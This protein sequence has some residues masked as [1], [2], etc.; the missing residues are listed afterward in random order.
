MQSCAKSWGI[1]LARSV[2][3]GAPCRRLSDKSRVVWK[4]HSGIGNSGAS[5]LT[6]T[7][8][9]RTTAAAASSSSS[10]SSRQIERILP[11]H[12][13]FSERH[14]GPG[15]REKREMLDA[16]GVETLDQLI[17]DTVP[18][19]IRMRRSMKMDDPIC[20]SEILD[21]L[22][23]IASKNKVWRSY[24][25]MGYYNCLV[26]PAIQRNLLENSGW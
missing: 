16:L 26:P 7:R 24:I 17:E 14:I 19:S 4:L 8:G 18:S 21:T 11:R 5:F 3:P 10:S 9:L 22:Q 15:E 12:D 13:D 1:F 2:S 20:E 6:T 25:G 23:E